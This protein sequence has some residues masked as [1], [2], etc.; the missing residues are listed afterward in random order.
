MEHG[1]ILNLVSLLKIDEE[2]DGRVVLLRRD[3]CNLG[4]CK[5]SS[6]LAYKVLSSKAMLE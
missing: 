5:L 6:C 3:L 2:E 1:E 4:E